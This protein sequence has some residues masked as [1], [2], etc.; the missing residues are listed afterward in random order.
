[1]ELKPDEFAP[2]RSLC[3]AQAGG[4]QANATKP[5]PMPLAPRTLTQLMKTWLIKCFGLC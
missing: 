1:V 2:L 4:V 3:A 5:A